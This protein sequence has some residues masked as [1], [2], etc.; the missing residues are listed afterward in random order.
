ML[1]MIPETVC[2]Y[3]WAVV[4]TGI[5]KESIRPSPNKPQINHIS[6]INDLT[7]I[8][9]TLRLNCRQIIPQKLPQYAYQVWKKWPDLQM[10]Q[11]WI[12]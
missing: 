4:N 10:I 12:I 8:I 11:L 9:S 6:M 1:G 3:I 7:R 2:S 5:D